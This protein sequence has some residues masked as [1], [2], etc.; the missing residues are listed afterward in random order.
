VLRGTSREAFRHNGM[1]HMSGPERKEAYLSIGSLCAFRYQGNLTEDDIADKM[2]FLSAEVM[3]RRLKDLG[4]PEWMIG[5]EE[6]KNEGRGRKARSSGED[7]DLPLA[8]AAEQ[9]FREDLERLNRYLAELPFLAEYLQGK[10][11]MSL[12][13]SPEPR[14]NSWDL[15]D[16]SWD[17]YKER[18]HQL[19]EEESIWT[20]VVPEDEEGLRRFR[21]V[22]GE[23]A[24]ESIRVSKEED[25]ERLREMVEERSIQVILV[26]EENLEL[27]RKLV[28][29]ADIQA[30]TFSNM[31]QLTYI[32]QYAKF[33]HWYKEIMG[34]D[35]RKDDYSALTS[36]LYTHGS[37]REPWE[38]LVYLIALH[39]LMHDSIEPLIDTL[40]PS[41]EEVDQEELYDDLYRDKHGYV[42]QLKTAA[43]Q[44]A[45]TVRG[46]KVRRG[47]NDEEASPEEMWGALNLIG[48]LAELGY[49]DK[50]MYQELKGNLLDEEDQFWGVKYTVPEIK[51]LRELF[52][53]RGES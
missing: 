15:Y 23:V 16:N 22:F 11:F 33:R 12:L 39:M 46:V 34:L 31:E 9:L 32:E 51:R 43:K 21:T 10:L 25:L 1:N 5:A 49:S 8:V 18:F 30:I 17:D 27:V 40:H 29:E 3:H 4:I 19:A 50:E 14:G 20:I 7:I 24:V 36:L 41:P 38:G 44:I 53:T 35:L 13:L 2:G 42:T 52:V 6:P 48:T 47:R 28:K 37:K 26:S 45:K